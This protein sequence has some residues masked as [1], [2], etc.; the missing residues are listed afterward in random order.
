LI[1]AEG[2]FQRGDGNQQV[3]RNKRDEIVKLQPDG[4]NFRG[5][6]QSSDGLAA[7]HTH[8]PNCVGAY[9]GRNPLTRGREYMAPADG[10]AVSK[11]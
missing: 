2:V 4:H 6:R 9:D 3:L 1:Y 10:S 11:I 8:F 7:F 5:F